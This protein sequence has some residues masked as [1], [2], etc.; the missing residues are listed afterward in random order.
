[1]VMP[2]G[3]SFILVNYNLQIIETP[4]INAPSSSQW[5]QHHEIL[6]EMLTDT[7]FWRF[8]H[9]DDDKRIDNIY[10]KKRHIQHA[11]LCCLV[12]IERSGKVK[13]GFDEKQCYCLRKYS[14]WYIILWARHM[15][16]IWSFCQ[17]T[18]FVCHATLHAYIKRRCVF[19]SPLCRYDCFNEVK[20]GECFAII[21]QCNDVLTTVLFDF[22]NS[23]HLFSCFS[24][25]P[26]LYTAL[27]FYIFL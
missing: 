14:L 2:V 18:M 27:Y 6:Q 19:F 13:L 23:E 20:T 22:I 17:P 15:V 10:E 21:W 12:Y 8:F 26:F 11:C 9:I 3:I 24:Y 16:D 4:L 7:N 1:M 25:I 5:R